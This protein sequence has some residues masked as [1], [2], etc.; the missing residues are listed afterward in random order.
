[1][2]EKEENINILEERIQYL[3]TSNQNRI[4]F[5]NKNK[6]E[7]FDEMMKDVRDLENQLYSLELKQYKHRFN[8]IHYKTKYGKYS[9]GNESELDLYLDEPEDIKLV[10]A[11]RH[12][13]IPN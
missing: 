12:T 7:Q 1:M 2:N 11:L 6:E 5:L 9:I 3:E 4:K 10:E 13:K 8:S